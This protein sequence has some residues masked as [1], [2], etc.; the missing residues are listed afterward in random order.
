MSTQNKLVQEL[1]QKVHNLKREN[2]RE[3]VPISKAGADIL[4]FVLETEDPM[5]SQ[6]N[7][8]ENP[9]SDKTERCKLI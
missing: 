7:N 9:F 3:R 1:E 5:L 8:K 2:E 4:K 6:K